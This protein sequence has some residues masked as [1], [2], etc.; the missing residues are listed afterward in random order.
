[1]NCAGTTKLPFRWMASLICAVSLLNLSGAEQ[2]TSC[3]EC[4]RNPDFRVTNRK[5]FDYFQRWDLSIHQQAGVSC[6]DCHGG[7]ARSADKDLAHQGLSGQAGANSSI[8]FRNISTT[9]GDC[10]VDV[11]EAYRTSK[12]FEH[13]VAKSQERQGPTCVTCHGSIDA[14]VVNVNTASET[15]SVCHN[16]ESEN[17]PEF[18]KQTTDLLYQFLSAQRFY[19]YITV[20]GNPSETAPFLKEA[21]IKM[22]AL[23]RT[24]H[25]F[26]LD[27]IERETRAV[28]SMLKAKRQEIGLAQKLKISGGAPAKVK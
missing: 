11:F 3:V 2:A 9:C 13:V 17:H 23:A 15:C 7:N 20:R 25:T 14:N 19:R 22:Q 28:L 6:V 16:P 21:D 8:N 5:L 10:H 4:H 26:D 27:A 18:P 1:M 24:W 12:H